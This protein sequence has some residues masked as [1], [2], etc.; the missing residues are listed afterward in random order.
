MKQW[1]FSLV[2]SRQR[3]L[4]ISRA[5]YLQ[6][7]LGFVSYKNTSFLFSLLPWVGSFLEKIVWFVLIAALNCF[8]K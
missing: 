5:K 1:L 2:G 4:K 7:D 6:A 8:N 3:P